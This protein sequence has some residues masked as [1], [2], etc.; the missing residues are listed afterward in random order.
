MCVYA[1]NAGVKTSD[2]HDSRQLDNHKKKHLP[3]LQENREYEDILSPENDL[4]QQT[5]NLY[6]LNPMCLYNPLDLITIFNLPLQMNI[7][8]NLPQKLIQ[9]AMKNYL[10]NLIVS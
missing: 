9:S 8:D 10:R 6:L 7:I 5:A 3:R 1:Q 4:S 2:L